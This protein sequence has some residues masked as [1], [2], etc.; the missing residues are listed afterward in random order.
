M[1]DQKTTG[2]KVEG[3]EGEEPKIDLKPLR[4]DVK[5]GP[6]PTKDAKAS[7]EPINLLGPDQ[8][9]TPLEVSPGKVTNPQPLR[10][11]PQGP[12]QGG[13]TPDA[14]SNLLNTVRPYISGTAGTFGATLGGPFA[15]VTGPAAYTATDLLQKS[16]NPQ[17]VENWGEEITD[18]GKEALI[19][20]IGGRIFSSIGGG[21][22]AVRNAGM[23]DIY[24]LY[25]T[26]S[27]ALTHYGYNQLGTAAKFVED[28]GAP[29]AKAEALDR[30]GG[31]GFTQA[32]LL[33]N[34]MNSGGRFTKNVFQ[35]PKLLHQKIL[36][37][38][39]QGITKNPQPG[40]FQ[41]QLHYVSQEAKDLLEGSASSPFDA[42]DEVLNGDPNKLNKV[43]SIGQA[44]GPKNLNVRKD[45]QAYYFNRIFDEAT[46][47]KGVGQA[48]IDPDVI[49]KNWFN[50]KTNLA[51]NLETLYGKQGKKELDE[52]MKNIINT[53]DKQMSIPW[54]GPGKLKYIGGGFLASEVLGTLLGGHP[55]IAGGALAGLYIPTAAMGRLLSTPGV[56]RFVAAARGSEPLSQGGRAASRLIFNA[57]EGTRV[58][59]MGTDNKKQWGS[60]LRDQSGNLN[61]VPE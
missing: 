8:D 35:D 26:S 28:F 3:L 33:S 2:Y 43:L 30:A 17:P 34:R 19:N 15:P 53:Q 47:I 25:P 32:L 49:N 52:F 48:R 60:V 18:S 16:L 24:K 39:E 37:T 12:S 38:L 29:K 5:L 36:D 41:P 13:L 22:K 6:M 55:G 44:V 7:K 40:Q 21:I 23:P 31:A 42:L 58:A 20:E 9:F 61:F 27:Q 46:T 50:P 56:S 45:L 14:I 10:M 59:L 54:I 51:S 57:L 11:F 4:F 1:A